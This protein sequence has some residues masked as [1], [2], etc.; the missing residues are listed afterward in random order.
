MPSLK[1]LFVSTALTAVFGAVP[2][3]AFAQQAHLNRAVPAFVDTGATNQR[4]DARFATKETNAAVRLLSGFLDIWQPRTP[5]VDAGTSA[6]ARDG[7]PAV[8][9]TDWD[10]I[11]R[12]P[13]DGILLDQAVHA[14]NIQTVIDATRNRTA[15]Q[16][17]EAY[18]DDRR[19]KAISLLDGL[20]PLTRAWVQGTKQTTTIT[21]VA[22][23]ATSRKYEDGGNNAGIGTSG[24]NGDLG[25][26]VDL[27]NGVGANASTEP[28][29]RYFK[30][31]RPFRWSGDVALLPTLVPAKSASPVTDGGFPSGHTAEAWRDALAMAYLV[32]QRFQEMVTRAVRLGDNRIVAGMHSPLDVIGGRMLG[33]ASAVYNLNRPNGEDGVAWQDL[34]QQAYRQTQAW[35]RKET[36]STTASDLYVAAHAADLAADRFASRDANAAFVRDRLTYGFAPI[37]ATDQPA[38]VPKGAEVLLETRLPYLNADQRRTVLA[39]TA[40]PSGYPLMN[41]PEGYGRLNIFAA[42]DGYGAFPADVAVTMDK[43]LDGFN[44]FDA[45][46]NDIGGAGKLTK[47]GT[48]TLMLTGRNSYSGGTRVGDGLLVGTNG[49]AFGTGP[50]QIDANGQVSLNTP[51]DGTMGNTLSGTGTFEKRGAGQLT[52]RGDGSGFTGATLVNGGRL[53]LNGPWGGAVTVGRDATL[54]GNATLGGLTVT[55]G[56]HL[57]PGNSVGTI[58]VNGSLTLAPGSTY[59][60]EIASNG[61]SDRTV[62]SGTAA[63]NGAAL[64]VAT[65]DRT[66]S[67]AGGQTYSLLTA[68]RVNGQFGSLAIDSSFLKSRLLYGPASVDLQLT[69]FGARPFADAADTANQ[70]AA[71]TALGALNPSAGSASLPLYNAVLFMSDA[72]AR[73]AFDQLSG[74]AHASVQS[75]LLTDAHVVSDTVLDRLASG[76][77]GAFLSGYGTRTRLGGDANAASVHADQGGVL[78]GANGHVGDDWTLG[79]VTGWGRSA[80]DTP[81]GAA[82]VTTYHAGLY[83]EVDLGNLSLK[84]GGA[85]SYNEIDAQRSVSLGS[86]SDK[87]TSDY[88]AGSAEVFG[89]ASYAFQIDPRLTLSP[90]ANLSHVTLSSDGFRER[91][92]AASLS[93]SDQTEDA[94]FTTLGLR[95]GGTFA[96]QGTEVTWKAMAGWV[97]AFGDTTPDRSLSFRDGGGFTVVG[98]PIAEDAARLSLGLGVDLGKAATLGVS[99]RGEFAKDASSNGVRADLNIRF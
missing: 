55:E 13:T 46:R 5:F 73:Q 24:G 83:G 75:L 37:A 66:A 63:L 43:S 30:Y 2:V 68:G 38:F 29:K 82:D 85:Y 99:Y 47:L 31:G 21:G 51:A 50:I 39:T 6:P 41:D 36:N 3:S 11:P 79:I 1:N 33:T 40:L 98:A 71:A 49:G 8:A 10:G 96:V 20:G 23:D 80:I 44:A 65:L 45:W 91:G 94:T 32:P 35:L 70:R 7:F 26:A 42:A 77:T 15:D 60:V 95:T 27:V 22:A 72:Q 58:T 9:P 17:A 92:G 25:L 84:A 16:A 48:G 67:Y 62:V 28:A 4:G 57:A 12:S 93:A 89:E 61:T 18:L 34:K 81:R 64:R 88:H 14:H 87:L 59:D 86:F 54:G 97:H 78:V 76:E 52:Y 90:F 56:G 69:T 53:S 19:N 74:E